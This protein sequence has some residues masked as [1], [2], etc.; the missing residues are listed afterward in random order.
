MKRLGLSV[1]SFSEASLPSLYVWIYL[2][3]ENPILRILEGIS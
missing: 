3:F 2:A 1:S